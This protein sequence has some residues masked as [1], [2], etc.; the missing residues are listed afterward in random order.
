M[1]ASPD[2]PYPS[3]PTRADFPA[4]ERKILA[5]WAE[6]DAFAASIEQRPIDDEFVFYDGPPFANG[7]P[8]HG[9]LL[10]G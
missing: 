7:L 3:V 4:I 1:S 2:T 6:S 8:H 10:T 5:Q 9:H